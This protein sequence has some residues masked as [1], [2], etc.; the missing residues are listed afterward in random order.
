MLTKPFITP[1]LYFILIYL[2]IGIAQTDVKRQAAPAKDIDVEFRVKWD[3]RTIPGIIKVS[4]LN[5]KTEVILH[6]N[7]NEPNLQ[8]RSAG[9]TMYEPITIQRPRSNDKE[10]EQWANKVWHLGS[11]LGSEMSLRDYR[12]DMRIELTTKSGRV[13]MAFQ[14]YRCWPSEYLALSALEAESDSLAMEKLVLQH[15]G[16]ERDYSIE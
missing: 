9:I 13:L 12:K 14:V 8:R 16:W 5:R 1:I 10:F 15:E 2:T 3:G 6:R 7:G 11:G 4:G